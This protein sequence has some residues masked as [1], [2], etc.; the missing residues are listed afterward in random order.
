MSRTAPSA[1]NCAESTDKV[2]AAHVSRPVSLDAAHPANEWQLA[3]PVSFC[4]DW[5]GKKD[6]PARQTTVRVLWSAEMLY[7]RFECKYRDITVFSDSDTNG[8]RDHLWDRDVVEVFLQPDASKARYY[9]EFEVA[10]NGFW[11]D[12]DVSPQPLVDLKS[13]LQRSV[14]LDTS[15]QT[16]A[17]ELAIPMNALTQNFDPEVV[18]RVNFYRVEGP[19]EPR[20]YLAWRPTKT[21]QPNFHVPSAFGKLRFATR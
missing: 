19:Q 16:W 20:A 7:L 8:R 4:A 14:W 15:Q 1:P 12:L 21:P 9:K 3:T 2:V 18:W 11:I 10:P 13:G 6:D 5:A 17:A